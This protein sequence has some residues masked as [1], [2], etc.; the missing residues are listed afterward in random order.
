[1]AGSGFGSLH[2][3]C[4]VVDKLSH[5]LSTGCFIAR[6]YPFLRGAHHLR[7]EWGSVLRQF[8]DMRK[9]LTLILHGRTAVGRLCIFQGSGELI[10]GKDTMIGD[11][12]VIGCN[13]RV[14]IGRN[15]M[16]ASA[17]TI[18]DTDHSFEDTE[19]PMN[20]QGIET[21]AVYIENNVWIGH[22]AVVLKGVTVG[23]G[24]VVA[25]GAV[26]TRDVPKFAIVAGLPARVVRYR[27]L[28]GDKA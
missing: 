10:V 13:E 11:F 23:E 6:Y 18:R 5:I 9:P 16:I 22:G 17:V 28:S 21:A 25:A 12:C 7:V 14:Q 8:W 2:K 3:L 26:V 4:R 20:A 1:M 27:A 15:V 19:I 24:A